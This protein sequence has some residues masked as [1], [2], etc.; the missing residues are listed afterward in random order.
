[1]KIYREEIFLKELN[2]NYDKYNAAPRA[3]RYKHLG[4]QIIKPVNEDM[5][6]DESNENPESSEDGQEFVQL[7]RNGVKLEFEESEDKHDQ[8]GK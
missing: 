8:Q 2:K 5:F 4:S 1:M 6:S 7:R 3:V